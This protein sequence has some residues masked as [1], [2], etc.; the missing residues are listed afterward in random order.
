MP[1][2]YVPCVKGVRAQFAKPS[3]R[4]CTKP[5]LIGT[6]LN[7]V[8]M[9]KETFVGIQSIDFGG[10]QLEVEEAVGMCLLFQSMAAEMSTLM[11][12]SL[13]GCN[14]DPLAMS[15]LAN[16]FSMGTMVE[17]KRCPLPATRHR[18]PC[19]PHM[20]AAGRTRPDDQPELESEPDGRR[21][22]DF[23]LLLH[24]CR[25]PAQAHKPLARR[26]RHW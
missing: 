2:W 26:Q 7:K 23:S 17:V 8:E 19:L 9:E 22:R 15:T 21:G 11:A 4:G 20:T 18:S 3:V 13:R 5:W 1:A 14:V 10:R 16:L 25:P 12:F 6:F 24:H